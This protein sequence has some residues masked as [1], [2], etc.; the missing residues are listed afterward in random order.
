MSKAAGYLKNIQGW[1][2]GSLLVFIATFFSNNTD[3]L[4][5]AHAAPHQGS[6]RREAEMEETGGVRG[7]PKQQVDWVSSVP[8]LINLV[9]REERE[10]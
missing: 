9:R 10:S 2:K 3:L 4:P 1:K 6:G 7:V 8:Q 5:T